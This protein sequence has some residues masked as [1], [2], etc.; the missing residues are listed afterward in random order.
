MKKLDHLSVSL[1]TE[2]DCNKQLR[3][4]QYC[5]VLQKMYFF[6]KKAKRKKKSVDQNLMS[7]SS[8][9]QPL[10]KAWESKRIQCKPCP[11]QESSHRGA[12]RSRQRCGLVAGSITK[13]PGPGPQ[14]MPG[15]PS[16]A[17]RDRAKGIAANRH[18]SKIFWTGTES[19]GLS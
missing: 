10:P 13:A 17:K 15:I 19:S 6:L 4:K 1:N 11:H 14:L 18:N 8:K 3:F 2:S 9:G 16:A 12:E 7:G 5:G